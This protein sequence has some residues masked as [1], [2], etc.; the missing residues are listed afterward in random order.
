[1]GGFPFLS[2]LK[3]KEMKPTNFNFSFWENE[4]FV[5]Y[6]YIVIGGGL[7]GM[8]TAIALRQKNKKASI[9][10]V[11]QGLLPTGAS[12]K[13]AGFACVG[14]ATELLADLQYNTEAEVL[15][16]FAMRQKGL[17]DTRQLL[18]D[19]A[20]EYAQNG[21]Y[22]LLTDNEMYAIDKIHF[23]NTF[24]KSLVG[25][26]AFTKNDTIISDNNF[27]KNYYK[28]AITNHCE[29]ELHAGK[30]VK[31][32]LHYAMQLGIEMRTGCAVQ[33]ILEE[34]NKIILHCHSAHQQIQ[35]Q[36]QQIVICT[37][38][39]AKQLLPN[40]DVVPGRG[41][42]LITKPIAQL[43]FKGIYHL[44]QGYY[45]FRTIGDRIL[46][47]GGR[48]LDVATET[49]TTFAS[50]EKIIANL[51]QQLQENILPNTPHQIDY[52]W[53]GIMAFGANKN[54]IIQKQTDRIFVAVR[55]GG[56][57]VAIG[58]EVARKVVALMD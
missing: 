36:A 7:V 2:G 43:P 19:D 5:H 53:S 34:A 17:A 12:T 28:A 31:T 13:N 44:Q 47:G 38:A 22:E 9:L 4:S 3:K 33:S 39:F 23:L 50:N 11:E 16:L 35:L 18:G 55:C 49:V 46:F 48:N 57:G 20:I 6:D 24:L 29:G 51:T 54:P 40:V 27:N 37:N 21:S 42:V 45:Y 10:I 14:S 25:K 32:L 1:L 8:H 30:L 26:D 56:M 15:E 41:Q 52:S 58:S